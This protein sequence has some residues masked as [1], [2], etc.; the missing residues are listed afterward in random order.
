VGT[1]VINVTGSLGLLAVWLG[2]V[3]GRAV[4]S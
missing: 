2:V 4:W 3:A 1:I